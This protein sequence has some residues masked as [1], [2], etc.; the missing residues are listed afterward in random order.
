MPESLQL[1]D[2]LTESDCD[3]RDFPFMPIEV[4]R[5]R[6][7]GLSATV[8][9]DEFR[10]AVLLW[11]ASWHQLP[12]ASLP[13]DD[14]VLAQLA[15]FGRVVRE[16]LKVRTGSL[17]GWIKCRDGRLYHPTVAEKANEAW[18]RRGDFRRK[19]ESDRIRKAEERSR[20]IKLS[21]PTDIQSVSAGQDNSKVCLSGGNPTE[22][23]L[24]GIKDRERDKDNIAVA[25]AT[26]PPRVASK[27]QEQISFDA[28]EKVFKNISNEQMQS[29]ADAY[30]KLDIDAELSRAEAWYVANPRK[31][32]KNHHAFLVNWFARDQDRNRK[33]TTGGGK[34]V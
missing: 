23:A 9:G 2:T 24:T 13:D 30:P 10:C 3:L 34:K 7:S 33:F 8:S 27:A 31:R 11:C 5:L 28:E 1:P 22:N 25:I 15:G 6:D 14:V 19:K 17:H 4:I 18:A 32:K 20:K 29:W 21:C 16:W 26:T 12:A